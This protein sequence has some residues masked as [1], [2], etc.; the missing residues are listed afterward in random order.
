V[1]NF[2]ILVTHKL[3]SKINFSYS[4]IYDIQVVFGLILTWTPL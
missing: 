4:D 1:T 2:I 3:V